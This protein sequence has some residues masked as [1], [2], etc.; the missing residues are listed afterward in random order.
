MPAYSGRDSVYSSKRTAESIYYT[1][2]EIDSEDSD[3]TRPLSA[4]LPRRYIDPWDF[5]NYVY[6]RR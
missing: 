4:S 6:V 5:E 2:K 3:A 1:A